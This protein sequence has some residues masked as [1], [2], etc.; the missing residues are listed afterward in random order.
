MD[1]QVHNLRAKR[2]DT[3]KEDGKDAKKVMLAPRFFI[4]G[5][6]APKIALHQSG[7]VPDEALGLELIG[8]RKES[9]NDEINL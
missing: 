6:G 9:P 1:K 8:G 7:I 3:W 4:M 5:V 2:V